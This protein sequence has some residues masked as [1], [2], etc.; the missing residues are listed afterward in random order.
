[1]EEKI[2]ML[3]SCAIIGISL[4]AG[5]IDIGDDTPD[6]P[7]FI[8]YISN[9]SGDVDPVDIRVFID[10]IC[11]EDCY[12]HIGDSH[13][14]TEI[15]L[16][17]KWGRHKLCASTIMGNC[18]FQEEFNLKRNTWAVLDHYSTGFDLSLFDT[19]P[20]FM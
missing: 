8:L 17:L 2:G 10:E 7:N 12:Y 20:V 14:W 18:T 13:N 16:T 9:Q 3:I 1:M 6:H 11:I 5:C 19:P 15:E 4:S